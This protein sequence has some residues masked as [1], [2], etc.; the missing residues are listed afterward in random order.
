MIF[1]SMLMTLN[2]FSTFLRYTYM[3]Q[4]GSQHRSLWMVTHHLILNPSKTKVLH[5]PGDAPPCL[6]SHH[7]IQGSSGQPS[8]ILCLHCSLDSFHDQ[9]DLGISLRIWVNMPMFI[10]TFVSLRLDYCKSWQ[11]FR[12][13]P[14][15]EFSCT[16]CFQSHQILQHQPIAVFPPLAPYLL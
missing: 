10:Q 13:K 11:V 8:I 15:P 14:S 3:F 4:L 7:L 5:I 1:H 9:E 6:R 2:S 12:C 16:Y